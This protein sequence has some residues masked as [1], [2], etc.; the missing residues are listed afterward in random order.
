MCTTVVQE[1]QEEDGSNLTER[2]SARCA[3]I[4]MHLEPHCSAK[5][6]FKAL[7]PEMEYG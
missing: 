5:P 1:S 2:P 6:L 3:M 7:I 4:I